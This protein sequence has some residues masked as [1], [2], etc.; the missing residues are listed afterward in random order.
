MFFK[1]LVVELAWLK[2]GESVSYQV[3]KNK[4]AKQMRPH[5]YGF[6]MEHKHASKQLPIAVEVDSVASCYVL[7]VEHE[8]WSIR[9][10]T[11]EAS[12]FLLQLLLVFLAGFL[13]FLAGFFLLLTLLEH[14]D[15]FGR[16][17]A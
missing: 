5:V 4:H 6:V 15:V 9:I 10:Q 14:S 12:G 7:V 17:V 13:V 8:L 3:E 2:P 16:S 11:D 1:L